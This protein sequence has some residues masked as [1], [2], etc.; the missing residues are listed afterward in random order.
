MT[1]AFAETNCFCHI[2]VTTSS[3]SPVKCARV[4]ATG[5]EDLLA[6]VRG[7]QSESFMRHFSSR[8]MFL[9]HFCHN[10][11][12]I[13]INVHSTVESFLVSKL[14]ALNRT[15]WI[16]CTVLVACLLCAYCTLLEYSTSCR[17]R[18]IFSTH[19]RPLQNKILVIM[20]KTIR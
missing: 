17:V 20:T 15:K 1:F 12:V 9:S 5:V 18:H 8:I 7:Q 16:T 2:S 3:S 10:T 14:I 13:A 11:L 6:M 4:R 19:P